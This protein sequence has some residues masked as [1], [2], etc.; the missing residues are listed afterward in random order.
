V[1]QQQQIEEMTQQLRAYEAEIEDLKGQ[2][3]VCAH[4]SNNC[5]IFTML[6]LLI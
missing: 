1:H 2:L 5:S 4:E 3:Q 6:L